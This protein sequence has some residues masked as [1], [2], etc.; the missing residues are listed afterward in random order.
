M[1]IE[2]VVMQYFFPPLEIEFRKVRNPLISQTSPVSIPV[3]YRCTNIF[4]TFS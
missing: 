4:L 3:A 2:E 1:A